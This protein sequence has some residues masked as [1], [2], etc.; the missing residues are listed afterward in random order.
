MRSFANSCILAVLLLT[1]AYCRAEK[2][3]RPRTP[4][5]RLASIQRDLDKL[6]DQYELRLEKEKDGKSLSKL[7]VVLRRE[8]QPIIRQALQLAEQHP[9]E[10]AALDALI[11]VVT[12]KV[13]CISEID[14]AFR[15]LIERHITSDKLGPVCHIAYGFTAGSQAAYDFLQ[16]VLEKS[17]NRKFRGIACY[18]LAN[19]MLALSDVSRKLRDP[20]ERKEFDGWMRE[21][22]APLIR[23]AEAGDPDQFTE[24]AVSLFN[25]VIK[26]YDD[27]KKTE[28]STDTLGEQARGKLFRL[29]N[30]VV[31]KP[32]PEIEG[33]DLDGRRLKLSDYRGKVVVIVFWASWCGGCM[34]EVP[35]EKELVQ[36]MRG[37]PFVLLGVNG[38]ENR[39]QA[40]RAVAKAG[41]PWRSWVSGIH[42]EGI[43]TRWG[44]QAWPTIFVVD[45]RGMLCHADDFA[46]EKLGAIAEKLVA[47]VEKNS[48]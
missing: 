19:E 9:S 39:D 24:K 33:E 31:G 8:A 27:V 36:R 44:I 29:R 10:P 13:S 46:H 47:G 16:A 32:V 20:K 25:R 43:H 23:R 45:H 1:V 15:I 3:E 6:W 42:K 34:R 30:L 26:E 17:P 28:R 5:Q 11:W 12:A 35:K 41:I 22:A 21:H 18:T 2:G 40:R 38:D 4:A 48:R 14:V 7:Y 37:R